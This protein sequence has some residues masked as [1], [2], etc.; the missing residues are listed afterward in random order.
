MSVGLAERNNQ[1]TVDFDRDADTD[2][3]GPPYLRRRFKVQKKMASSNMPAM[4]ICAAP[5]HG[6]FSARPLP[7]ITATTPCGRKP[8]I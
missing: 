4:A 3:G 1:I 6:T 5:A 2:P 7:M 8:R